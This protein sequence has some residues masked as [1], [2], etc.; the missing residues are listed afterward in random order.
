MFEPIIW[1]KLE[2]NDLAESNWKFY[3]KFTSHDN[4]LWYLYLKGDLSCYTIQ[5]RFST[6]SS[7][8]SLLSAI[9]CHVKLIAAD[10][11]HM[12]PIRNDRLS[13]E[14]S[15][16]WVQSLEDGTHCSQWSQYQLTAVTWSQYQLTAVTWSRC[17]LIA[18]YMKLTLTDCSHMKPIHADSLSHEASVQWLQSHEASTN[19]LQS[20]EVNTY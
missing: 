7:V 16:N 14:A 8:V 1:N 9:V 15:T 11:S 13:H 2:V 18:F 4:A 17:T 3:T 19:W 12:A 10:C 6:L 5:E 20:H